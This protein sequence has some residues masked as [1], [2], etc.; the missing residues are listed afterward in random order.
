MKRWFAGFLAVILLITGCAAAA[1]EVP[2]A[3]AGDHQ[4]SAAPAAGSASGTLAEDLKLVQILLED[5]DFRNLFLIE[6]VRDVTTEIVLEILKWMIENRPV[7][8]KILAELGIGEDDRNSISTIW[9]SA[10][11]ISEA[12]RTY[13]ESED[14]KQL[15]AEFQSLQNDPD[16]EESL[17]NI[18]KL[19]QSEDMVSLMNAV[20]DAVAQD[21][22]GPKLDGPLTQQAIKER[23]DSK[24]YIGS[25]ILRM[26][27]VIEQCDWMQTS[28]PKLM[29]NEV[30]WRFLAHLADRNAAMNGIVEEEMIAL[31]KDP[32]VVEFVHRTLQV[33]GGVILKA[34]D[35]AFQDEAP[36]ENAGPAGTEES[37]AAEDEIPAGDDV[38]T[39]EDMQTD[40]NVEAT[41]QE[42]AP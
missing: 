40:E 32:A 4:E 42:A 28:L 15:M 35:L 16:I 36:E 39:E 29:E 12:S 34:R 14:G 26:L 23:I 30:L 24:T 27:D 17:R 11:R 41:E 3:E 8:M 9:D 33:L 22:E 37:M 25:L 38:Q 5:E 6:D 21:L 13:Y 1:E 10:E 7:T 31:S 19:I 20:A 18:W 2:G